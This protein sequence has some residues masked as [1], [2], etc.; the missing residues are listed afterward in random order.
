MMSLKKL[1]L[2]LLREE[3]ERDQLLLFYQARLTKGA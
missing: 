2:V 1:N 3:E